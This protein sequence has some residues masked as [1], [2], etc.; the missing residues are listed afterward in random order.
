[1][2]SLY[3]DFGSCVTDPDSGVLLQNRGSFFSLDPAHPNVLAPGKQS[4]STLMSGML[5][6]EGKPYM[7]YGTQEAKYN[8]KHRHRW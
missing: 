7:V 3:F 1:V 4:A 6:K 5:Y 2:Q 8:P